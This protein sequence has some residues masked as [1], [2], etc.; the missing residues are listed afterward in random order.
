MVC[1]SAGVHGSGQFSASDIRAL[2]LWAG[3]DPIPENRCHGEVWGT[4]G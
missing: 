4:L 2:N 1:D 3:Y